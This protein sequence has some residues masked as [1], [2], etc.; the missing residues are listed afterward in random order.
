VSGIAFA[1]PDWRLVESGPTWLTGGAWGPEGGA[2]AWAG[3]LSV[4]AALVWW[5]RGTAAPN[6][7]ELSHG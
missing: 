3:M 2:A 5:K 1:T 4:M 6:A 7:L